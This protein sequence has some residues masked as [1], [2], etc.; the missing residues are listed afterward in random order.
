MIRKNVYFTES[1][2]D[3]LQY[4]AKELD[5]FPIAEHIRR[6]LDSYF[7]AIKKQDVSASESRKESDKNG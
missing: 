3:F 7:M 6:A 4:L 2:W 1:Q 5:G